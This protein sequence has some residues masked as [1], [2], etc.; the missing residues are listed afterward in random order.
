MDNNI[1]TEKV[2]PIYGDMEVTKKINDFCVQQNFKT[3]DAI[4]AMMFLAINAGLSTNISEN[5]LIE[6]FTNMIKARK[7]RKNEAQA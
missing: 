3:S 6:L 5:G 2:Y 4:L 7:M 1:M